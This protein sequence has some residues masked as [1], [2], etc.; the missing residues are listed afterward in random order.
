MDLMKA[1]IIGIEN[2]GK[3]LMVFDWIKAAKLIKK[4]KPLHASAG[5]KN[6]W[7]WTGGEIYSRGKI[8]LKDNTYTY[9]ASTWAEPELEMDGEICSCYRM[10]SKT[11]GWDAK[12]YWPE[13]AL[14][15][16]S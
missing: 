16:L 3:E 1:L 2:R 10:Q 15:I 5:L 14:L 4:R 9:L 13:E 6:D 11:P 7:N 12:T 8:I